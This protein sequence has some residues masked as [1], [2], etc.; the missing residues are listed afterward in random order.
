MYDGG[1]HRPKTNS[2]RIQ[3]VNFM[4]NHDNLDYSDPETVAHVTPYSYQASINAS[5]DHLN[6]RVNYNAPASP[7]SPAQ[8]Q[9]PTTEMSKAQR[10]GMRDYNK[11]QRLILHTD[12]EDAVPGDQDDEV[13]ELPP[14]YN[15]RRAPIPHLNGSLTPQSQNEQQQHPNS[16]PR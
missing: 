14:Q 16:N 13:V 9:S 10:A 7:I 15:E 3:P 2:Q 6:S 4:D 1:F 11:P 12:A 5:S 8:P